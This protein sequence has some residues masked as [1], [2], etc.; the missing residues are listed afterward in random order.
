MAVV[1][2]DSTP[3]ASWWSRLPAGDRA[4][5]LAAIAVLPLF[6]AFMFAVFFGTG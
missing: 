2:F 4:I 1:E 3:G 5:F 6:L